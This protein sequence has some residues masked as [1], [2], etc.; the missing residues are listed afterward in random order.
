MIPS[1]HRDPG[2]L[3][4][5][6]YDVLVIGGGIYGLTVA[7]D[8]AQRGLTV[9]LIERSDFGSATTFNHLRTIHGGLRYLQTLDV[10]RARE[11]VR[12]RRTLARIAPWA[13]APVPFVLPLYS[14][15]TRGKAAMRAAFLLDSLVAGDRNEGLAASHSLPGGIVIDR[16]AAQRAYPELQALPITGAAIWHDYVTTDADRLTLGWLLSAAAHGAVAA[17]YV[18]ATALT[19]A[20]QRV[21]GAIATDRI[22]G[23]PL[24]ITARTVVNAAGASLNSLLEPFSARV[25]LPQLQ[26]INIVTRR[27]APAAAIGGRSSA[28]RNLFLVPW[29]QRALFGTWES[30]ATCRPSDLTVADADLAAFLAELNQAFPSFGLTRD[31]VA[32]VHRGVVPARVGADGVPTLDGRELVFEHRAEGLGGLISVAGTKYTTAR[33][34]AERIVDRLFD[35]LER[36]RRSCQSDVTPLP[37]VDLEGDELLQHAARHEMVVTLADAVVRRTPLGALGCPDNHSLAR[38]ARIVAA[39]LGWSVDR[40]QAEI[41]ALRRLY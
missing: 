6:R 30:S 4:T 28:G 12:E 34:V 21:T 5:E 14:S 10:A 9:A 16:D 13:V 33:A 23:Q 18:E 11:S 39:E 22:S 3:T 41:E 27:P 2:R 32:L 36:P 31:D 24:A 20:D 1:L 19:T 26:A 17:N 38:A 40:E 29:K 35:F 37:H 7:A 25:A 15:L 8:A